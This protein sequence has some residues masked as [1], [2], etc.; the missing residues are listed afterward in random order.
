MLTILPLWEGCKWL[1]GIWEISGIVLKLFP[2]LLAVSVL[3]Y[4]LGSALNNSLLGRVAA[5]LNIMFVVGYLLLHE[6]LNES[7]KF[8]ESDFCNRRLVS[9]PDQ[10]IFVGGIGFVV[11][12][13]PF[14]GCLAY[15]FRSIFEFSR[16]YNN[17]EYRLVARVS[18]FHSLWQGYVSLITLMG[19]L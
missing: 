12:L 1:R 18:M 14:Y 7:L 13:G 19:E 8:K 3:T 11:L 2:Y 5:I 9:Y 6:F 17:F 15:L 4:S 10:V 16:L